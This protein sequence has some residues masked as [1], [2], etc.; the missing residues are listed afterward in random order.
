MGCKLGDIM[1][2]KQL[3]SFIAIAKFNSFSRAAEKLYLTQPTLSNHIISLEREL[4][5]LLFDRVNKK[6]ALTEAGALFHQH[7]LDILHS[8]DRAYFSL[9]KFKGS[10]NGLLEISSSTVPQHFFLANLIQNFSKKYPNVRY[11]IL[12]HDSKEVV[13]KII[14]GEVDFGIVGKMIPNRNIE[15]KEIMGDEIVLVANTS[16]KKSTITLDELR[17][18]SLIMRENGSATRSVLLE[19]LEALGVR[20]DDLNIVAEIENTATIKQFINN[21]I[22][23]AFI[24]TREIHSDIKCQNLKIIDVDD[25]KITRNFYFAYNKRISFSPL[26]E[27]FK[28]YIFEYCEKE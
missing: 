26:C 20:Y 16:F 7:A 21:G 14:S 2:F 1:D 6:V 8:R 17:K 5:T 10:I 4:D 23:F 27:Q 28:N 13:Q 15:Y 24:S 19:K 22:G 18:I 3:E 9:N 11:K 25:F 12:R